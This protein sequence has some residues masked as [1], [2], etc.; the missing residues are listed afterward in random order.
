M[1]RYDV[2]ETAKIIR[3]VLKHSFPATK[4]SVRSKRYS[5][6]SSIHVEWVNG[7]AKTKVESLVDPYEGARFDMMTDL[8]SYVTAR[9]ADGEEV[10]YGSDYI[11]ARREVT[12]DAALRV[13]ETVQE[14]Y[15]KTV[16]L[17][18][19][20]NTE[21]DTSWSARPPASDLTEGHFIINK[22]YELLNE[23]DIL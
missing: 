20:C 14:R 15:G 16:K 23:T 18:P 4:F 7:P 12:I 5:G 13:A 8:K 9:N 10:C 19:Y 22:F 21:N 6:G 17:V 1:R 11:F 2:V 3:K